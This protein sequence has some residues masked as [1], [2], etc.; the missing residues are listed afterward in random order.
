MF[1]KFYVCSSFPF[2]IKGGMWVV[3]VLIP[4]HRLPIYFTE[5]VS[6]SKCALEHGLLSQEENLDKYLSAFSQ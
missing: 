4:D 2:G 3:I 5:T 6:S 1:V